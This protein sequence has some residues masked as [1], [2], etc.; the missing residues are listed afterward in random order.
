ML[1]YESMTNNTIWNYD[2]KIPS[3]SS[4]GCDLIIKLIDQLEKLGWSEKELFGVHV[5]IEEAIM[6][7]IR[8]GNNFSQEKQVHV[9]AQFSPVNFY[10]YVTDEGSGFRPDDV[11][12]P[13]LDENLEMGSGRGLMLMRHYMDEVNY[14]DVGNSVVIQKHR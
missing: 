12:D 9:I 10:L 6:N 11:P 13:T 8:H 7:A 4:V 14:N 2:D 3:D 5:A 1:L